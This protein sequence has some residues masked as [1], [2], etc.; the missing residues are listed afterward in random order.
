LGASF[1]ETF[2]TLNSVCV[3][4]KRYYDPGIRLNPI[5]RRGGEVSFSHSLANFAVN[6]ARSVMNLYDKVPQLG[7]NV[8][9]APNALVSGNVKMGNN[10]SV[11]YG[12]VIRGALF[13]LKVHSIAFATHSIG[14][15]LVTILTFEMQVTP[16]LFPS[17]ITPTCR[18]ERQSA[19]LQ[20]ALEEEIR[21]TTLSLVPM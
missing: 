21:F 17:G 14:Y 19:P 6:R 13:C 18:T 11:F 3:K 20:A 15:Q 9:V 2:L 10:A 12:S 4:L 1:R 8:F 5:R 7:N 16:A